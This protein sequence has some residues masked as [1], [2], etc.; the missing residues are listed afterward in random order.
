[1]SKTTKNGSKDMPGINFELLLAKKKNYAQY[2]GFIKF[3]ELPE[4]V[5]FSLGSSPGIQQR[6]L[7]IT[8]TSFCLKLAT[9]V[10]F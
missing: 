1:M 7:E 3:L 5:P 9:S 2:A 6:K 10:A 4:G 8:F